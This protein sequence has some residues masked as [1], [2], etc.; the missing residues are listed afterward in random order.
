VD[1]G[2]ADL[3]AAEVRL[4]K[5]KGISPTRKRPSSGFMAFEASTHFPESARQFAQGL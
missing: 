5:E 1:Q 2:N 3:A 4:E